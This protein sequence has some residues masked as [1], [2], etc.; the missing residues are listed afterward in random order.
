[1]YEDLND[2]PSIMQVIT[3]PQ[4]YPVMIIQGQGTQVGNS[5]PMEM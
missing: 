1:M 3:I 5:I 4:T 2:D